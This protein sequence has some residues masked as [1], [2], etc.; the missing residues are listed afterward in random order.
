MSASTTMRDELVRKVAHDEDVSEDILR[1]AV[2]D[3]SSYRDY[4]IACRLIIHG[5][6]EDVVANVLRR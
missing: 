1:R 6:P 2:P 3:D 4:V 5:V